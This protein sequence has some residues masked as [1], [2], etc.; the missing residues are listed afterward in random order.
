MHVLKCPKCGNTIRLYVGKFVGGIN[1][2]GGVVIKCS[3]CEKLFPC[4]IKNPTDSSDI[5]K[6]GKIIESWLDDYP[7]YLDNKYNISKSELLSAEPLRVHT[8][9]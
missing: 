8:T 3:V 4:N 1:D 2:N 5:P 7:D 9:N 6:G